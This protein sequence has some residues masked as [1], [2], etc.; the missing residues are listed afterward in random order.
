MDDT[1]RAQA[2][3]A[4][5]QWFMSQ[6]INPKD[7]AVIMVSLAADLLTQKSKDIPALQE[8]VKDHSILLAIE[9]ARFLK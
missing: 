7:A 5:K 9:I 8:A 1:E 3:E 6:D 2:M 4:L